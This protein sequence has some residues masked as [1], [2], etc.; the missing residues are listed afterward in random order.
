MKLTAYEGLRGQ[1][2]D[3]DEAIEAIKGLRREGLG[4][5][6]PE[7]S[8]IRSVPGNRCMP[9]VAGRTFAGT[10]DPVPHQAVGMARQ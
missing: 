6:V 8:S 7:R 5:Y 10:G 3:F 9:N 4:R 2:I 1:S